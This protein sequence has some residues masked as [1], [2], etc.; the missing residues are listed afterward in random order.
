MGTKGEYLFVNKIRVHGETTYVA[1]E[2]DG[3]MY[4]ISLVTGIILNNRQ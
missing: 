4:Y 2:F 1:A 3:E